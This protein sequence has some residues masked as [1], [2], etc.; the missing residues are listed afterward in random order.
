MLKPIDQ[1]LKVATLVCPGVF[2]PDVVN[3]HTAFSLS[4]NIETYLVWK[5]LEPFNAYT[6]WPMAATTTFNECPDV[7]VLIV[8]MMAPDSA[9]DQEILNF[10]K[11]KAKHANAVIGI[12][13]GV[14][15]LGSA[16]LLEG[17]RATSNFQ[18]G[19][20]LKE[21][22]AIPV[23]TSEVVIDGNLYTAGPAHGCFEAAIEVLSA[24]RGDDIAKMIELTFEYNPHPKF[25]VGSPSLAGPELAQKVSDKSQ[26]MTNIYLETARK[27]YQANCNGTN[28]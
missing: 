23:L 26:E 6:G 13:Y 3:A 14:L 9:A 22:G 4:P 18:V 12:C 16:G 8:G 10:I 19:D 5:T 2:L 20:S 27:T 11:Q 21:F 15:V 17:K 7:D 28:D 24:L 25:K 1:K